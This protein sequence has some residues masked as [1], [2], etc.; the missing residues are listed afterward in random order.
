MKIKVQKIAQF[1]GHQAAVY[2][3]STTEGVSPFFFSAAGDGWL[4]KWN[5]DDPETGHLV[6][7]TDAQLFSLHYFEQEQKL[8]AGD[9]NGGVHWIDLKPS[10]PVQKNIAQH[11]KGVFSICP[12]DDAVFTAGGEGWLTKWDIAQMQRQESLALSAQSLRCIDYCPSRN[13]LAIGS[14]DHHIYIVDATSLQIKDKI[15]QAHEGSVFSIRYAPGY[16]QLLS[17]GRDAH[18]KAWNLEKGAISCLMKL[19]A[20]LF[21]INSIAFH[22]KGHF[23]ATASRDKTIKIWRYP[24]FELLKVIEP[25]RDKGHV[26]SVNQLRWSS[27]KEQLV[28]CSDDRSLI[29]WSVEEEQDLV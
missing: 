29:L 15:E 14:S 16:Q 2:A 23:F 20:H 9:M 7:K 1:T 13:E 12:T 4:V 17:G 5:L 11:S 27:Y 21:T 26:N 28:S 18:L 19:P 25:I 22:P 6:A 3:I 8:L 10:T 24:H